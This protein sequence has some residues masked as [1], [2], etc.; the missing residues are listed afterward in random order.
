ME[1]DKNTEDSSSSDTPLIALIE[2]QS[3]VFRAVLSARTNEPTAAAD[4]Q[5]Q[6]LIVSKSAK[7]FPCKYCEKILSKASALGGHVSRMHQGM[8]VNYD[9]R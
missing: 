4:D 6:R 5:T 2:P 9:K 7:T 1:E 3:L 8:S